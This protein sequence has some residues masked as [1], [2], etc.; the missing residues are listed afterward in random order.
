MQESSVLER[1]YTVNLLTIA[2]GE[3]V[4]ED[5]GDG[6]QDITIF[7]W[8]KTW[9]LRSFYTALYISY[10]L[11]RLNKSEMF[12]IRVLSRKFAQT[13]RTDS[14]VIASGKIPRVALAQRAQWS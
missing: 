13:E 14:L 12:I 7:P 4:A 5:I 1:K 11:E 9:A 8:G 6:F 10:F 2:I 3:L